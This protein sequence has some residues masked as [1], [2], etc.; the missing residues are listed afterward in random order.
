VKKNSHVRTLSQLF[1]VLSDQTRLRLLA[2]LHEDG[3][4]H[5]TQLCRKLRAPQ[6]TVSHHLGLLRVHGLVRARREGKLVYYSLDPTRYNRASKSVA[7]LLA[8][9]AKS[10]RKK[11][12]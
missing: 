8:P 6:P 2:T 4:Q 5:V 9:L 11:R 1:R 3:E 12:S 10:A 7:E